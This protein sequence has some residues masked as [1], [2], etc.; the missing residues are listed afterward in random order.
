M[1]ARVRAESPAAAA[2][3]SASTSGWRRASARPIGCSRRATGGSTRGTDLVVGFVEAHG[4][5]AHARA[6]RRPRDRAP[7]R[8]IEYRGVVIEEMDTDAVIARDPTVALVDELAHT[9]VPGS[10]RAKRWED[11]EVIRDAGIHVVT[12]MNVQHL[13]SHRRRGRDDHRR[14]GQR[15]APRRRRSSSAD[16]IELVD[17]SPHALR[18]RMKHGN[19]YPPDRARGRPRPVL[20]GGE[21]DG[22]PGARRSGSSRDGSRASSRA[23]S[24]ASS[25]R[26]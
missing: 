21:S 22:A 11:V 12:T 18:Q 17:M 9:N 26:S 4:R 24:R 19:V 25:C 1:L 2:A 5:A 16:E 10:A 14:P 6:A 15:A 23:R 13:E 3:A 20:H 8:R 7:R